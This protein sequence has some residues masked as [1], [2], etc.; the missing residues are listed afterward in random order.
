MP[1]Y[2]WAAN[3]RDI[4]IVDILFRD[5]SN[6]LLLSGSLNQHGYDSRGIETGQEPTVY[7]ENGHAVRGDSL[8]LS[9]LLYFDRRS[10][11]TF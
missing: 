11:I 9:F 6:V 4:I 5:G 2:G 8:G 3:P 10:L 7:F 1:K